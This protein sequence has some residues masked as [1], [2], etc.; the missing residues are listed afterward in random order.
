M[1][2]VSAQELVRSICAQLDVDQISGG[3]TTFR[4][5]TMDVTLSVA[6]KGR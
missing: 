1:M 5:S 6:V 2:L 4:V 3:T